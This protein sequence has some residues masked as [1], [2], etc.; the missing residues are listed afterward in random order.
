MERQ[1]DL[2]EV[3]QRASGRPGSGLAQPQHGS[4]CQG[5]A[6]LPPCIADGVPQFSLGERETQSAFFP[7]GVSYKKH[8]RN[9]LSLGESA[10]K[11]SLL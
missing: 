2:P 9:E 5:S 4:P 6:V 1:S 3:A 11:A 8:P 7:T 10:S